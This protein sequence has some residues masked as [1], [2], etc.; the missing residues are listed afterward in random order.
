MNRWIV[1]MWVVL[2]GA[3]GWAEAPTKPADKP[4]VE[5]A[6]KPIVYRD[7]MG[8]FELT[9]P[10]GAKAV[11][12]DTTSTLQWVHLPPKAK[13]PEWTLTIRATTVKL[14]KKYDTAIAR[15]KAIG[16]GI[17]GNLKLR[18]KKNATITS[19]L[20]GA[21][22]GCPC[23]V[24]EG[25]ATLAT[26]AIKTETQVFRQMWIAMEGDEYLSVILVGNGDKA[27]QVLSAW[28]QVRK[29]FIMNDV[30]AL[31]KRR[32]KAS[33]LA[34]TFL[35]KTASAELLGKSICLEPRWF[36]IRDGGQ[37]V[38]WLRIQGRE[39]TR[40]KEEGFEL[41]IWMM[42]QQPKDAKGNAQPPRLVYRNMFTNADRSFEMW[43]TRV[44][45]GS[46]AV[47]SISTEQGLRRDTLVLCNRSSNRTVLKGLQKR[48]T[49]GAEYVYLPKLIGLLLPTLL[50]PSTP[51]TYVFSEY[52]A[53]S[54]DYR[55]RQ[56]TVKKPV[57]SRIGGTMVSLTP[58]VDQL[59]NQTGSTTTTWVDPEGQMQRVV[60]G[61]SRT[62]RA[63]QE[64]VLAAYPK[65][66][67]ICR[68]MSQAVR[69]SGWKYSKDMDKIR[70]QPPR[71]STGR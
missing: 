67:G 37:R 39:A 69:D 59:T 14:K 64:Q 7:P 9:L 47:A 58:V 60:A 13:A 61:T 35:T 31:R 54:N 68:S 8:N 57:R 34:H 5:S 29:G 50:D 49:P 46:G 11:P 1:T 16:Q 10:V 17:V 27:E 42:T 62:D 25:I 52:D 6:V 36:L 45:I 33:D 19:H 65:A 3:M 32:Q 71:R 51:A 40:Q 15:Q 24:V 48:M 43:T 21:Q 4:A 26:D 20:W 38:G 41:G 44:Q 28:Q 22:T 53:G 30:A 55:M 12:T 66:M 18:F 2:L 23:F 56:F 63:T 70:T